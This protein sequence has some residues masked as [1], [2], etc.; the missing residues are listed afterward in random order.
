MTTRTTA[1]APGRFCWVELGTTDQA[2][3]KE[4]YGKLFG[5]AADDRPAGPDGVYTMFQHGGR[6]AG[7][8]YTLGAQQKGV[9][10]NW[11]VYVAVTS[12]DAAAKR[13]E[14]LGGRILAPAF[15]VFDVGRMAVLQDPT[16]AAFSVW[17]ARKHTGMGVIDEPGAFCWGELTTRDT[18]KAE[19]FYT[20]LFGWGAKTDPGGYT[21]WTLDGESIGGMIAIR[22]EWGDMPSCWGVY[23]QVTDCDAAVA[24]V[25]SLG[26]RKYMGPMDVAGVGRFAVVADPQGAAFSVI[27][28]DGPGH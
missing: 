8:A 5:W 15:D 26:G 6:D 17:E 3:A 10:P 7:A 19:A 28:L 14:A 9:P 18:K 21:E 27:R 16:G 25:T 24:K 13:A 12:A 22:P 23:F 11:A 2:A 4:F 1:F 20:A